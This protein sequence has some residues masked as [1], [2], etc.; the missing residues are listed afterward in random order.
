M[1]LPEE[2]PCFITPSPTHA[3]HRELSMEVNVIHTHTH[4]HTPSDFYRNRNLVL[5]EAGTSHCP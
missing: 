4:T 1:T 2:K 3:Q 5:L